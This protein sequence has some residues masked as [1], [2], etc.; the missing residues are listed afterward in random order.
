MLHLLL[1]FLR[2]KLLVSDAAQSNLWVCSH[3]S[4][5]I[6]G[7]NSTGGM[8]VCLCFFECCVLTGRGFCDE[9]ITCPERSPTDCG[10][11]L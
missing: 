6:V 3:S 2:T 1:T 10:A 8:D 5:D 4:A 7:S 9:L 11:S